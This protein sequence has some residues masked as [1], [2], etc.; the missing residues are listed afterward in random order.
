ML[1]EEFSVIKKKRF[2]H[3]ERE[4]EKLKKIVQKRGYIIGNQYSNNRNVFL[5][6]MGKIGIDEHKDKDFVKLYI[7]CDRKNIA[8]LTG[9]IFGEI[10]NVAGDKL[11][12]KC[13]SEQFLKED[14]QRENS[15][16]IKNYQRNDKIV[17]YAEND[18]K[19][20][21]IA[22]KIKNLRIKYPNLFSENK[23]TPLLPKKY[24][25]IGYGKEKYNNQAKTPVGIASGRT[26]NEYM[27]DI[28]CKC[29]IAGFDD[30]ISGTS[31]GKS[32]EPEKRM[33]EYVRIYS[34]MLPE[35]RNAILS[36][37]KE[38]FLQVCKAHGV[39][40]IYTPVVTRN[41]NEKEHE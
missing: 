16:Q 22:E 35:Q 38:I 9:A 8:L 31:A 30:N 1:L 5:H 32:V 11:Q 27:S 4:Q 29:I 2:G 24:G 26:Y 39:N 40:T 25:F 34:E 21:I 33:S 7:N 23:F 28:L 15:N 36:K 13:I 17:I 18:K 37:S 14:K 20:E 3:N 12:M 19:A 41:L 10:C 6:I